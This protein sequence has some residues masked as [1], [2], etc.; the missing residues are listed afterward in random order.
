MLIPHKVKNK[1]K[2]ISFHYLRSWKARKIRKVQEISPQI[3]IFLIQ[4][5]GNIIKEQR[6]K[7]KLSQSQLS[8]ALE[9]HNYP[10]KQSAISSWEQDVN[11][12]SAGQFLAVCEILG[13]TDIYSTFIGTNP[14]NKISQLNEEDQEKVLEYIDLLVQSGRYQKP[15]AEVIPFARTIR[16][17]DI[18]ASAGPGEF[19][20]GYDYEEITVGAEVPE[21]ADFGIRISGDSME[22]RFINGQIVWVEQTKQLNNGDIGI[23]FL[24][25]NAYCKKLQESADSTSLISLNTKYAPIVISETSSF[26]TF[27]RVVG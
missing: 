16:L 11:M 13:I 5:T 8:H 10:I 12:P 27:G 24:D 26:Y 25:G 22:P 1:G 2:Y 3:P 23:F 19:L 20:D 7:R 18:P 4:Q 17:F 21:T 6:K 14:E 9:K 15:T